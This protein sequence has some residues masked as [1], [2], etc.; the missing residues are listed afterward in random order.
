MPGMKTIAEI[1]LENLERL[2]EEFETADAVA[3][4][5]GTSAVYLSQSRNQARDSKTKKPRQLGDDL[6]RKLEIGC[7][8]EIGWMDHEPPPKSYRASRIQHAVA[9][10]EHME[11]WQLDQ[12]IKIVDTI[13][14]PP[15]QQSNGN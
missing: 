6:A 13:A 3:E 14:Q 4:M 5:C 15:Q 10:M 7:K 1:R 12:A 8:K 9:V 2:I 11:D